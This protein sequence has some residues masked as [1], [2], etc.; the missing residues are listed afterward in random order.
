MAHELGT[1]RGQC[2]S[3]QNVKA[4]R[5]EL[6]TAKT[7]LLSQPVLL[8]LNAPINIVGDVHGQYCAHDKRCYAVGCGA[9]STS[10]IWGT[11]ACIRFACTRGAAKAWRI[12]LC[13]TFAFGS[14]RC[15]GAIGR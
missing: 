1:L 13:A 12:G 4:D 15:A 11:L 14:Q 8:E 2:E 9:S 5:P 3:L 7:V 6:A 10:R